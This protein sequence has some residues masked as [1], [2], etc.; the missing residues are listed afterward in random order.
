MAAAKCILRYVKGTLDYSLF[1]EN[2]RVYSLQGYVDVDWARNVN[3]RR[4][5]TDNCF[6]FGSTV[7][8]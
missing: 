2:K 6:S 4:S 3:D 7:I 8:S 5:T 1:Y